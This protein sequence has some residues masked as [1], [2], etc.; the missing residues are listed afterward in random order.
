[1]YKL[2][3]KYIQ[4]IFGLIFS[5]YAVYTLNNALS[6]NLNIG[7]ILILCVLVY[8]LSVVPFLF[9]LKYNGRPRLID[10]MRIVLFSTIVL[11]F[12]NIIN[13]S[14]GNSHISFKDNN[15]TNLNDGLNV[16]LILIIAFISLDIGSVIY[17]TFFKKSVTSKNKLK[18]IS[19]QISRKNTLILLF[20]ISTILQ[21]YFQF[22]GISGYGSSIEYTTGI[23]SLIKNVQGNFNQII[24]ILICYIVFIEKINN[25]KFKRIFLCLISIQA[26]LGLLSGMKENFLAPI[27]YATVAFLIGGGRIKKQYTITGIIFMLL[28]YPLNSSYRD[29]INDPFLNKESSIANITLAVNNVLE[30]PLS[31]ILIGGTES[32]GGRTSMYAYLDNSIKT[33]SSWDYYKNMNRYWALPFVWIVPRTIWP[34][35]PRANVGAIYYE[36]LVGRTTNSITPMNIGWAYFEGGIV[37]VMIIF[38]SIG[39]F[40]NKIDHLHLKKPICFLFFVWSLHQALKPEW[41]P[42]FMFSSAIQYFVYSLLFIKF[43]GVKKFKTLSK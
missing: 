29:I 9:Y 5:V 25:V 17:S 33:E 27:L 11:D 12:M 18:L 38:I 2:F 16:L 4:F 36:K 6:L 39:F 14:N 10:W 30:Q 26:L 15:T 7:L 8:I 42:Y 1:M 35:K 37:Y 41:D 32:Y 34:S 13:H 40:F 23:F 21:A 19:Y 43:I 3:F 28:L 24:L 22:S 31:E 20:F